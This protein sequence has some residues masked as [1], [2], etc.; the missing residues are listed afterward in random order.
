MDMYGKDFLEKSRY[1]IQKVLEDLEHAAQDVD[2]ATGEVES[3]VSAALSRCKW[4]DVVGA[5]LKNKTV[6]E[7]KKQA[8]EFIYHN[9][10]YIERAVSEAQA[11]VRDFHAALELWAKLCDVKVE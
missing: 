5:H 4:N 2:R 11:A 8:D 6:E 7:A 1:E 3:N 9:R 10:N